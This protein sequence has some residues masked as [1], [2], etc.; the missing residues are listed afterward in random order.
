MQRFSLICIFI[1]V[2][3][4]STSLCHSGQTDISKDIFLAENAWN[5]TERGKG[6][7]HYSQSVKGSD[8]NAYKG[9]CLIDSSIENV[10]AFLIDVS[11]HTSWIA[12][13][14]K[15]AVVEKNSDSDAIQYYDFDVPWP[16]S[17]RDIVVHCTTEVDSKTGAITIS[18]S[19]V[20]DSVVPLKKDHLRITDAKQ[21]WVI[22]QIAPEKTRVTLYSLTH[23]K[24]PAP[25]LLK[26]LVSHV[27]P[28]TS[29][30]NLRLQA[31]K[32]T[33]TSPS[34]YIAKTDAFVN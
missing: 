25:K 15:S 21:K 26:K 12:Y 22:E 33:Q 18:S 17:N 4:M 6:V 19:A 14:S 5:L 10:Y 29:L 34:R 27:I 20:K 3:S 32:N 13:C 7:T 2:F 28:S 23:I 9:V 11:R 8:L 24:G 30:K 16:L 31:M 1:M